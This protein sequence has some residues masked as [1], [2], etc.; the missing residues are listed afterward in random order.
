MLVELDEIDR[1][2]LAVLQGDAK[3]SLADLAAKVNLS[4]SPC[5][6]RV[7]RLEEAGVIAGYVTL[8]EGK[9]IGINSLAYV[10]VSLL[11]H[12]EDSIARFDA[13][14]QS[15]PQIIE[16][17]SITGS[18]DFMLKVVAPDPEGLELFI[19]KKLLALGLVRAANTH[20]VLRQTKTTTALPVG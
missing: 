3:I 13:F 12:T 19:M 11:E 2:I 17:A 10:Q 9:S 5:W 1:A 18:S 7:R 6:R 20:F 15:Q 4:T 14:V 8:L 16:C